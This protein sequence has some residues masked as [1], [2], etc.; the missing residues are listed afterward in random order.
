MLTVAQVGELL[1]ELLD[2]LFVAVALDCGTLNLELRD[3]SSHLIKF[4][5]HTI[6]LD[7]QLGSSFIDKVNGLVGQE[8]VA[9]VTL[10]QLHGGDDCIV[11][12]THL[13]VVLVA[14][15]Q[16]TQDG[17]SA[18]LV[19]LVDHDNLETT[20]KCLILLK[21]L[22]VL[23]EGGSTDAAQIATCEGWLQY[24]GG[25]HSATALASAHESVNLI[26]EEDNLALR[27]CNFINYCFKSF[28]K[29]SL[30]LSSGNQCAHVEREH[31]FLLQIL[32]YVAAYDTLRQPLDNGGFAGSWL[33]NKDWVV[34]GASAQDLEHTANLVVT[35]Y[36]WV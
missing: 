2:A 25:I 1:V 31:L 10:A 19:G 4:L 15:L 23:I 21:V 30:I 24:I 13:V 8:T 26:D 35:A 5:R 33:A 12:D 34:L 14:L 16:A 7:T 27:L 32:G 6:H 3:F 17:D 36:D 9:D 22:L 11:L 29:L 18:L 28:L 20:L